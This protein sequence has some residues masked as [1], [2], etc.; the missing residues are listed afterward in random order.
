M[1]SLILKAEKMEWFTVRKARYENER[2]Y[3]V[4]CVQASSIDVA[5][6]W[7]I[8]KWSDLI[9]RSHD[10]A[11][12]GSTYCLF[13]ERLQRRPGI[14]LVVQPTKAEVAECAAKSAYTIDARL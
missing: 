14:T 11:K 8:G 10:A 4:D 13:V 9:G 12:D 1:N 2:G 6:Q 5:F 7:A 3:V